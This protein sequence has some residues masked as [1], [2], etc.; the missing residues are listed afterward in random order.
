VEDGPT[1]PKPTAVRHTKERIADKNK[2]IALHGNLMCEI[3]KIFFLAPT[4]TGIANNTQTFPNI[5]V[6]IFSASWMKM[7]M[8]NMLSISN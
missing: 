5:E 3:A 1:G 6:F 7:M 8:K 4:M 2:I